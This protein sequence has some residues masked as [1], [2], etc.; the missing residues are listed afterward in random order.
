M[1]MKIPAPSIDNNDLCALVEDISYAVVI[2]ISGSLVNDNI[3]CPLV[4]DF[5]T[6]VEDNVSC[7]LV[8]DDVSC[9]LIDDLRD[10]SMM[11]MKIPAP[12]SKRESKTSVCISLRSKSGGGFNCEQQY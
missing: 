6:L 11:T 2:D 1:T 4:D 5:Y 7:S 9:S 10:Q 8:D 12:T 3:P